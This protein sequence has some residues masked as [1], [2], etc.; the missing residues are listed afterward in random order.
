MK[1]RILFFIL[2][3][4]SF[5]VSTAQVANPP[6]DIQICDDDFDGDAQNGF[7]Q[8]I[9]LNIQTSQILGGQNPSEYTVTYHVTL[10]DANSGANS[11]TSPFSNTVPDAQTIYARVTE[12]SS[13]NFATT[14]FTIFVL[15]PPYFEVTSPRIFC[16]NSSGLVL[17]VENPGG[18]YDYSWTTP[19]GNTLTGNQI[20]VNQGGSYTVTAMDINNGCTSSR[21]IEVF[22]SELA[23]VT[24]NDLN[25]TDGT[26][27]VNTANLGIGDYEFAITDTAMNIVRP[28]QDSNQF[29]NLT[30]NIYFLLVNDKNDCGEAFIQFE[31]TDNTA[32]VDDINQLQLN[33]YPNPADTTLTIEF[34]NSSSEELTLSLFNLQGKLIQK[35]IRNPIQRQIDLDVSKVSNGIYLLKIASGEKST[36]KKLLVDHR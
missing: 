13:G 27:I 31:I 36:T 1:L 34:S 14:N 17:T 15:Q 22:E 25:I 21:L 2:L 19:S 20:T 29:D 10:S 4:F 3:S 7:V 23:T 35:D 26:L 30:P 28:Y 32:S 12:N 33:L 6:S 16:R 18:T 9:D 5:F 8:N 24:T 11:L